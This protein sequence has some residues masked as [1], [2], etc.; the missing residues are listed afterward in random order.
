[1]IKN[2]PNKIKILKKL[3][4]ELEIK[5]LENKLPESLNELKVINNK[6]IIIP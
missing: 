3:V 1:M 6:E 2:V 4:N 5:L